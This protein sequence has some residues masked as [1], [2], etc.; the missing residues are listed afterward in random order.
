MSHDEC[1]TFKNKMTEH[2]ARSI[3]LLDVTHEIEAAHKMTANGFTWAYD[4]K[5]A[6]FYQKK[7]ASGYLLMRCLPSDLTNENFAFMAAHGLTN[8]NRSDK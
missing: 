3:D 2:K 7:T 4:E 6:H 1:C 8:T 5:G